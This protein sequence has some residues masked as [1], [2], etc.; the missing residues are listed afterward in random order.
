MDNFGPYQGRHSVD[1]PT[2]SP[3][4]VIIFGENGTG[5]TTFLNAVRWCLYG[6]AKNR[7]K[8]SHRLRDLINNDEFDYGSR[9]SAVSITAVADDGSRVVLR[10]E[11]R[12]K[13]SV[14]SPSDDSDFDVRCDVTLDGRVLPAA[15]FDEVVTQ[16]LPEDI[17]RFFLFDGELLTEYEELVAAESSQQA[18]RVKAA[19]EQVLGV[20]AA[21]NARDDAAALQEEAVRLHGRES[22]K[23]KAAEE[24][25]ER[26]EAALDTRD[27]QKQD[28]VDL[29]EMEQL[30]R[31]EIAALESDLAKHAAFDAD[32]R[33]FERLGNEIDQLKVAM[34]AAKVK[35][36]DRVRDLWRDI[37]E[38]RVSRELA[39]VTAHLENMRAE[40]EADL[41]RT[42]RE[43]EIRAMLND[44]NCALCG[45]RLDESHLAE[46][47][48]E[49]RD[50]ATSAA[51]RPVP[52]SGSD[53]QAMVEIADR[54]RN[55]APAGVAD[56]IALLEDEIRKIQSDDLKATQKREMLLKQMSGVDPAAIQKFRHDRDEK[57]QLLGAIE[58]QI[59]SQQAEI[60]ASGASVAKAQADIDKAN[61]P[62]LR[63]LA[64]QS[65]L[66][67]ALEGLFNQAIDDLIALR[68]EAVAR[69]A[70]EIFRRLAADDGYEGLSINSNYGLS[71]VGPG[72]AP[73][74]VRSAGYEQVVALSLI[75]ALNVQ[76]KRRGPV[77]M[78]TPFGRLD[79]THRANILKYLSTMSSQVILLV[80][81]GEVDPER[82]DLDPVASHI[83][84]Q[85]R[86][87]H[88]T[89]GTSALEAV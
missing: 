61:V 34:A 66:Y 59:E 31:D 84:A 89:I 67:E 50:I 56:G 35:R 47:R 13:G 87:T 73:V 53:I 46:C 83:S 19:I 43:A 42:A 7:L 26:L 78:D 41:K 18:K 36:V 72:G 23:H 9:W 11:V 15:N 49:L 27:A 16:L 32:S 52:P 69:E 12:A 44:S 74:A 81:S 17:S 28:L 14:A 80:H 82:G 22:R 88:P 4:L 21:V 10:R 51:E 60:A 77:I 45:Q 38:P 39:R 62:E 76:A 71:I 58:K 57:N 20:P 29:E 40:R 55:V 85:L 63:R 33:E 30:T 86:I 70:T 3:A 75:G 68:R 79:K 65:G 54:L 64:I 5:K 1:L 24:A 25:S 48:A 8:H 37:L 2:Q 6:Y